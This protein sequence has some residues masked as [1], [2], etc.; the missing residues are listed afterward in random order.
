MIVDYMKKRKN[1]KII[2]IIEKRKMFYLIPE[3]VLV[4]YRRIPIE[5]RN[6]ASRKGLDEVPRNR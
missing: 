2:R 6:R 1:K 5:V 4:R 3:H